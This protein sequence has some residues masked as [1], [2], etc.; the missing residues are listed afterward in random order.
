MKEILSNLKKLE[1]YQY[2]TISGLNEGEK[3]VLPSL[4]YDKKVVFVVSGDNFVENC[5]AQ[6]KA[7]NKKVLVL[8][9]KL[10]LI[11]GFNDSNQKAFKNYYDC[12]SRLYLQDFDCLIIKPEALFQKLPNKEYI[13]SNVLNIE[14][15]KDYLIEDI[16]RKL[17]QMGYSKQEVITRAGEFSVRGDL[18]D[19]FA[20][21]NSFPIRISFFDTEVEQ[22]NFYDQ[23]SFKMG[24]A[25]KATTIF[26]NSFFSS[27]NCDKEALKESIKKDLSKVQLDSQSML[28]LTNIANTQFEYLDE[29]LQGLSS[30][31]YLP[32][33]D[34]FNSTIFDYLDSKNTLVLI[35]EPRLITDK[36]KEIEEE[37][38]SNFLSLSIKGELLPKTME[39]YVERKQILKQ[40]LDFKLVALSRLISQNKLFDSQYCV[41]FIC[42]ACRRYQN[43]LVELTDELKNYKKN[44]YT[45]F[46]SCAMPLTLNKLKTFLADEKVDFEEVLGLETLKEGKIN[47]SLQN[48]PYSAHFEME[49]FL[50]VGSLDINNKQ[51]LTEKTIESDSKPKFLPKVGDYVVHQV[52]GVGKC[53]GIK[54]LKITS[55]N[56]DYIVIEYKDGDILYLPSENADMLSAFVGEATPK[57]NKIGGTEFFKVK[58]RVKNSIKEMAFD[59]IKVYSARLNSK[60]FKYSKDTYLQQDF[61]NAFPYPYT[62]DQT[63]TIKEIKQDM[64]GPKIMDRLVCGDVGFGK[65]EVALVAAFK[66]I[67]DGKQVAIIC[68]T[69]ILCEQHYN[70][71]LSRMKN[72]LV[73]VGVINRFKT[74]KEQEVI[75]KELK[76]G[77]IDLICGTHRLF[78]DDVKFKDLG[79]IILDEEQRFGV[80]DKE[81][82]KNLKKTV[83]VLSLSATP[84]P[85]TLYMSLVGIRDVSFLATA[86]KERKKI[87]TTVID[88]SDSLLVEA[89]KK[90][91]ERGG[92]VLIVYNKVESIT[93]FYAHVRSLLPEATISFAHGQM[94]SKELEKAIYDLYTRKTQILISTVLIENGVDLPYANTLFVIDADK[95]GLSQLYQLRGRIGRSNIDAYAYFS[96]QRNKTLTE[97]SYKRLDAIMEF[98]DFGSGYKIALRDLEIRGAGDVLGR[99]QHGHMQQVGYDMY[100]K[101]LNEAVS[102]LKGE[103]VEEVLE[104]KVDIAQNAYLP[105]NY[106]SSNEERI[107]FYTMV[108][109]IKSVQEFNSVCQNVKQKYGS[110]PQPVEQLCRVGLIK[111]LAQ[112]IYVKTVKIDEFSSKLIL[113]NEVLNTK[114]FDYFSKTNADFVLS[115]DK[116]P[117]ITL[118]KQNSIQ[119]DQEF[120]IKFLLNC[121]Q[122]KNN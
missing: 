36:I 66:A 89:C 43:K 45:I 104:A 60:G 76:E 88:Y 1:E 24:K 29:D 61:E 116:M 44:G 100:V 32:F 90:E 67:Q 55:S 57:C 102:E 28:R 63:N 103:K 20:I 46:V 96:F 49:H 27:A 74:K 120:L 40:I 99:F 19:I 6:L 52:H 107:T 4:L 86:P 51:V 65:T 73:S 113:H 54:N 15:G 112:T 42:P 23:N 75:L 111:N 77:K 71:A 8:N 92:Q 62:Q 53:L 97:D 82:L 26:C 118:R 109:R 47:I 105:P 3:Y 14:V 18:V 41:N 2:T 17:I 31:F 7:L 35:D 13:S 68:P 21:N 80:E 59:L 64:E 91:L 87:T 84:I 93:N 94:T 10:P 117:I 34:Y 106:I 22:I 9:E 37:N 83:D 48:I 81:K 72:F 25:L 69:T 108:S 39:L 56:R 58:Q 50:L 115:C 5:Q 122:I 30:V 79:L 114:L 70:T 119:K 85:R 98:N 101:L 33:C 11:Y 95:L 110:L 78:S 12:L 16:V 121:Q 38:V